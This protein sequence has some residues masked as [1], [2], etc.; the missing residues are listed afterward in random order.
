MLVLSRRVGEAL[1][2]DGDICITVLGVQGE[3]VRIG[4]TAPKLVRV[5]RREVHERRTGFE[6][7]R[8]P[9]SRTLENL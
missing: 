6:L 4:I 9:S 5:E 7:A 3:K 1:I 2:V 8:H